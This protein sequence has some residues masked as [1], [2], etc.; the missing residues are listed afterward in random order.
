MVTQ[1]ATRHDV[2]RALNQ[3]I[4]GGLPVPR[5]VKNTECVT[6]GHPLLAIRLD[7]L[8]EAEAWADHIGISASG[9]MHSAPGLLGVSFLGEWFGGWKALVMADEVVDVHA[10]M[11]E[12]LLNPDAVGA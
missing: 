10:Q 5:Y 7:C 8:D 2:W 9:A 1:I 4:D 6:G 11:V 12:A 3:A